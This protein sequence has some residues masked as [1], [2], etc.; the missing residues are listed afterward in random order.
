MPEDAVWVDA[1]PDAMTED[2][3]VPEDAG[4]EDAMLGMLWWMILYQRI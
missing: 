4:P 1:V 3:A 2:D